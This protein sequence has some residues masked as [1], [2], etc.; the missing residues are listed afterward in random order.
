[1]NVPIIR[2]FGI[3]LFCL[4]KKFLVY[5]LV[6]RNLKIK[7]RR[8]FFGFLW[9]L[10]VPLSMAAVYFC[11]FKLI[12]KVSIPNYLVFILSGVLPW[13]F[14]AQ[15]VMEG[16]ESIVGN[17]GLITKV[18]VPLQVFPLV[19]TVTNMIT[20]IL[21]IPI[22]LGASLYWRIPFG[23]H[24]LTI[25]YFSL[26]L[27]LVAYGFSTIFA[28]TLVYLRDLRHILSIL[29]Q[30][31]MYATPVIYRESMIPEEYRFMLYLNPVGMIFRGFHDA[32]LEGTFSTPLTMGVS[33]AWTI[34]VV[35]TALLVQR[36]L[37]KGLVE[38][39]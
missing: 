9:T 10:L 34:I 33:A 27:F 38:Q 3:D 12:L 21:S 31:W 13:T 36:A 23:F 20:F 6:G 26:C 15:T 37:G 14:F 19:G 39:L 11:V 2:P 28:I 22:M 7:Y 32:L 1:M 8:S 30:L 5:N 24:T 18:P 4:G 35:L 25:A 16:M 17:Q 29:M